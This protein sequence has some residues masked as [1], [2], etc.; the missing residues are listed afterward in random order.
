[1]PKWMDG[2]FAILCLSMALILVGY[3]I[4][5]WVMALAWAFCLGSSATR[6]HVNNF[7]S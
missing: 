7:E 6:W 1:M 5:H 3:L 4:D 2:S